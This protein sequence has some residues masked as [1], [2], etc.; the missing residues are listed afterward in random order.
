VSHF[1]KFFATLTKTRGRKLIAK[2][3]RKNTLY[4]NVGHSKHKNVATHQKHKKQR[5]VA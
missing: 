4:K 5:E 1:V 2:N 3:E